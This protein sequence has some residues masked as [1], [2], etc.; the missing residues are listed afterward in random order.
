MSEKIFAS[1]G[2][3]SPNIILLRNE[4]NKVNMYCSV[5]SRA[6]CDSVWLAIVKITLYLRDCA[7]NSLN[8]RTT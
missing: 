7:G 3:T 6:N 2:V 4:P 1:Y 5:K 8:G